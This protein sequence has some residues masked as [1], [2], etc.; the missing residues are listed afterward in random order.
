MFFQSI[1]WIK[2]QTVIEKAHKAGIHVI[3]MGNFTDTPWNINTLYNDYNDM[4]NN[5]NGCG[6]AKL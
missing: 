6:L 5:R 3:T 2:K 4:K 1:L